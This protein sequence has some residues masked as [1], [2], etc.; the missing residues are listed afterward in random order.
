VVIE[1]LEATSE[2]KY[3]L[4]GLEVLSEPMHTTLKD[5]THIWVPSW[6]L[7]GHSPTV[8]IVESLASALMDLEVN[9]QVTLMFMRPCIIFIVE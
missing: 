2:P 8:I 7:D 1:H 9:A 3:T 5:C 6:L 4:S